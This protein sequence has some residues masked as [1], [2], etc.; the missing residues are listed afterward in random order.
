MTNHIETGS[1]P[2]LKDFIDQVANN[3]PDFVV[4]IV[5]PDKFALPV[6]TQPNG[7]MG[8]VHNHYV[9]QFGL[10]KNVIGLL[11][12]RN[13]IGEQYMKL[14]TDDKLIVVM[15]NGATVAF[16]IHAVTRLR[17]LDPLNPYSQF[18]TADGSELSAA[19][20]HARF[21]VN[22]NPFVR[23]LTLQTC[24]WGEGNL[25]PAFRIFWEGKKS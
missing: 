12:E 6:V 14:T 21:Y 9:T 8:F 24:D 20:T 18:Q 11:A 23:K 25:M 2:T 1:I 17:A 7:D 15:G 10:T 5:A 22:S 13:G 19:Q 4:G 16:R 3:K